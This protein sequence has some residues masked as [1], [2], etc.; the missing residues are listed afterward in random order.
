MAVVDY[1]GV[2]YDLY[3]GKADGTNFQKLAGVSDVSFDNKSDE[4]TRNFIDGDNLKIT[5][6]FQSTM[7]MVLTDIGQTNLEKIV[8]G[9]VYHSGDTID[10]VTG[11][12][13]GAG[14]AVTVGVQKGTSIQVAGVL[15]LVPK[16]AAQ[17]AHT[18]FM[19]NAVS[20][21]SDV[22]LKDLLEEFEIT[23]TGKLVKGEL[24]FVA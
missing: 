17:S 10:G 21:I 7:K 2:Q 12:A 16:L 11:V 4:V 6:N 18:L 9:Y 23:V 24:T 15:K 5:T 14:G 20:T 8:P 19:L 22:T 3:I 1:G 13:V